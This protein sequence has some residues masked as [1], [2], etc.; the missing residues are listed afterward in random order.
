MSKASSLTN[1]PS[2][3]GWISIAFHWSL[4]IGV[5][6]LFAVGAWMVD[7]DYYSNWY[8]EAP[9]WHKSVG[10]IVVGAMVL[11]WAWNHV[12]KT[13]KTYAGVESAWAQ[14][15]IK[16]MHASL[17][18]LVVLIGISGYLIST[19]EDQGIMVFNWFEVPALFPAFENQ[20]DIMGD[21]HEWLANAL[22]ALV[23]L[24]FV[25]ALKHHFWDKDNTLLRMLKPQKNVP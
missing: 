18:V 2:Q 16:A 24:H 20:A 22:I 8:H 1:S 15:A 21:V 19:A 6:G 7:L 14:Y 9:F 13:P 3:Y 11:R 4:V 5:I 25:G 10:V 12:S 23:T 17:Y